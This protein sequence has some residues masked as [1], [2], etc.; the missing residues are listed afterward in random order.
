[1]SP[2]RSWVVPR[3]R[4]LAT[5]EAENSAFNIGPDLERMVS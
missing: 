3:A 5:S 4:R 1:L 2:R